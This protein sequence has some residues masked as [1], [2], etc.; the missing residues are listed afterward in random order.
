MCPWPREAAQLTA[1]AGQGRGGTGAEV[2]LGERLCH[3]L[4]GESGTAGV[5]RVPAQAAAQCPYP[6]A[7]GHFAR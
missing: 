5:G 1:D 7:S 4:P 3:D 6:C 2:R